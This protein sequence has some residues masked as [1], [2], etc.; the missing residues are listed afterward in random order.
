VAEAPAGEL[1]VRAHLLITAALVCAATSAAHA[2]QRPRGIVTI[3]LT[4]TAFADGGAIPAKHAQPGRDVSPALAWSGA[5]DS[6]RSYV[7]VV[8]D[9]DAATGNGTDDTLHWLVWN[10]PGDATSLPEGVPQGAQ[11][12]NGMRQISAS[13]PY[14]RGPAAPATGPAHHYVFELYALDAPVNVPAEGMSPAATRAAVMSA[15][16][17]RVRG[18]GVLVGLYRRPAP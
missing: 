2:Q 7:L 4:S 10:I 1:P 5:P 9:L 16:A 17:G 18:K 6:V 8:H 3:T 13:G 11:G 14:Y 15:L 12:A